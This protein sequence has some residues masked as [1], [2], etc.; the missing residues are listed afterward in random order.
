MDS[1]PPVSRVS[2]EENTKN[3]SNVQE[4]KSRSYFSVRRKRSGHLTITER[5]TTIR[6]PTKYQ[7]T[8]QKV[9]MFLNTLVN[10]HNLK[11][12]NFMNLTRYKRT[13]LELT[14]LIKYNPNQ[15][16]LSRNSSLRLESNERRKSNLCHFLK[17]DHF[18]PYNVNFSEQFIVVLLNLITDETNS[19]T[20]SVFV[21][22]TLLFITK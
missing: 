2:V 14:M 4:P 19:I 11:E 9:E 21:Q 5:I 22:K 7:R 10:G 3:G 8:N 17:K 6:H 20:R 15:G 1:K 12:I 16:P 18:L 13:D